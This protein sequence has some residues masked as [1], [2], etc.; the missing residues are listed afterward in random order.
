MNRQ[1]RCLW[2][3]CK[4]VGIHTQ[5]FGIHTRKSRDSHTQG[6]DSTASKALL[7]NDFLRFPESLNTIS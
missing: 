6:P 3:S 4:G 1:R 2:I 5:I 7:R